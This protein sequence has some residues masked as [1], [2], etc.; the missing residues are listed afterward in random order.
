M[1]VL[2]HPVSFYQHEDITDPTPYETD[3]RIFAGEECYRCGCEFYR[4]QKVIQIEAPCFDRE[5]VHEDCYDA[6]FHSVEERTRFE[7][8]M[9]RLGYEISEAEEEEE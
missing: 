6:L 2:D 7:C 8:I 1:S 5:L 3:N 4:G 9:D